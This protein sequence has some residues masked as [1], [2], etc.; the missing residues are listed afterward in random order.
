MILFTSHGKNP[1]WVAV[2]SCI[3]DILCHMIWSY[4]IWS[5]TRLICVQNVVSLI[6][7]EYS[8]PTYFYHSLI[9]CLNHYVI[10]ASKLVISLILPFHLHLL[11]KYVCIKNNNNQKKTTFLHPEMQFIQKFKVMAWLF[12]WYISFYNNE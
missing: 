4:D 1:S 12:P 6:H 11:A 10:R 3:R 8:I 9:S 5:V 2:N 7:L